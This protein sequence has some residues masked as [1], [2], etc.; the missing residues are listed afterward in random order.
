[1]KTT[2]FSTCA[3]LAVLGLG[4]VACGQLE[5]DPDHK[6]VVAT[7]HGQLAN[8]EGYAAGPNMRVAIVWGGESGR[9]RV[10]Q[11][12]AVE[13]VF[14]SQ[15]RIDVR[16]L[17]PTEALRVPD[18]KWRTATSSDAFKMAVGTLVAY[19]DLNGDGQLDLL[20]SNATQAIDRVVG[21]NEDMY[22]VYTEGAATGKV[23]QL[24]LPR[25]FSLLRLDACPVGSS[26]SS[27]SSGQPECD[28]TPHVQA[29]DTLFTLPLT[30][31]P[32]LSSFMCMSEGGTSVSGSGSAAANTAD[33]SG[34][35][36]GAAPAPQIYPAPNDPNLHCRADGSSYTYETCQ[37]PQLCGDTVC[38]AHI[39]ERP[40][41]PPANWPC[42]AR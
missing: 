14:P 15:F 1:M 5:G 11:D 33:G 22:V 21:V 16:D 25:G 3:F 10:S 41:A 31:S 24:G 28:P 17:P 23:A 29:I 20:D 13:P 37:T 40:A 35:G 34:S 32:Q 4:A 30:G 7:I 36:T 2:S 26:T 39:E 42:P 38:L 18:E 8:P 19:E 12:V 9:V 6:P 27:G